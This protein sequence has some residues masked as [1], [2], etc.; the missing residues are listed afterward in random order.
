LSGIQLNKNVKTEFV[1]LPINEDNIK[2]AVV[3][4]CIAKNPRLCSAY[5]CFGTLI[6]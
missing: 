2:V 5:M 4:S 1:C 6:L 3:V